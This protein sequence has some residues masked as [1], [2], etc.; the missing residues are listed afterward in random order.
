MLGFVRQHDG[1]VVLTV[2]NLSDENF[3]DHSYAVRTGDHFGKWTQL[4][5]SQDAA[6]G[7]WDGAGNAFYEPLHSVGRQDLY[8]LAQVERGDVRLDVMCLFEICQFTGLM[9]IKWP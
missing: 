9:G 7:G 6:Y 8:Q 1:N 5:C 4:L 3:T 2:V